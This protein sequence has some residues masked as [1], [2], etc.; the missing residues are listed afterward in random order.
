M[1]FLRAFAVALSALAANKLRSILAVLG[2]VI[3]VAAVIMVVAMG[4]GAQARVEETIR[5]MGVNLVFVHPGTVSRGS[6]AARTVS[7]E[8]LTLEDARAVSRLPYVARVAPE[9]RRTYQVKYLNRNANLQVVGTM[10]E[11]VEMRGFRIA[12]GAFFDR[13]AVAL[14]ERVCV[15]GARAT[16]ELFGDIDPVGRT[17]QIDRQSFEVLGLLEDKGGDTWARLDESV[18][19]P[20][21]TALYRLFNRRH[22]S[23]IMVQIDRPENIDAAL[24]ELEREMRR[25]HGLRA[26]DENDFRLWSMDEYRRSME[27]SAGA[28]TILLSG[29]ALVSLLV[30]GIGIMNIMLVSVTERTREIGIRKAIGARRRDILVQFLI[31]SMTIS[32]LGGT[33]GVA[34]GIAFAQVFPKLPI[35]DKLS[36]GGT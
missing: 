16:L 10:P 27:E 4:K 20:V 8:N 19:V 5:R 33:I 1:S 26:G 34:A 2:I 3:G 14:R 29:I 23:Q 22:L 24:Q 36:R 9:V 12:R 13:T 17:I 31:E 11:A 32:L 6:S 7:A 18:Y 28:F 15:M 25:L 35:W 21:T 30:G